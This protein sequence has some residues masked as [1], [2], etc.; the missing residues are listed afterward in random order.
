MYAESGDADDADD[1][2]ERR[3]NTDFPVELLA[4]VLEADEE[5]EL[6]LA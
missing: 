2:D 1:E 4:A 6:V 3:E 5:L